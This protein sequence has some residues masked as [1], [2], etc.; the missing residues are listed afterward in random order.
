MIYFLIFVIISLIG[1]IAYFYSK[2]RKSKIAKEDLAFLKKETENYRQISKGYREQIN[3][4]LIDIK[5]YITEKNSLKKQKEEEEEEYKREKEEKS[6]DLVKLEEKWCILQE[7]NT[8]AGETLQDALNAI[9]A[10]NGT[11]RIG[12]KQLDEQRFNMIQITDE[13]LEDISLLTHALE[14]VHK[15]ENIAKVIWDIYYSVPTRELM[16]RIIGKEKVSGVYKITNV[17]TEECYIGQGVDVA[18]RLTEHV[19]GSL[20]IQSI[21]DQ[22]IHHE[23]RKE[24]V[25]NWRFELLESCP[26][27]KLNERERFYIKT[28]ESNIIGFN[29]TGGNK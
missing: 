27:T 13:D 21:A 19:K 23:M 9:R 15:K 8:Q 12:K 3:Q 16:S 22:K 14:K 4:D 18:R 17:N 11:I 5:K 6:L 26:K 28:F 1:V 25:Q 2:D 10:L 29:R 20:G 7:Q 24:G